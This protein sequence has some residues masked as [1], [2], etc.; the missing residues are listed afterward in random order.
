MFIITLTSSTTLFSLYN[1]SEEHQRI[2]KYQMP[3]NLILNL[4]A[5]N[6]FSEEPPQPSLPPT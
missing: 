3:N 1:F 2:G 5:T 4:I 6:N